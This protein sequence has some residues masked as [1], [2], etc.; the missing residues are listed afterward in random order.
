[1]MAPIAEDANDAKALTKTGQLA[2][3]VPVE[4]LIEHDGVAEGGLLG[5]C[6]IDVRWAGGVERD[7]TLGLVAEGV[8]ALG[9]VCL[10]GELRV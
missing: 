5:R 9:V 7:T 10:H 6:E 2:A 1:M 8:R 4:A 3:L